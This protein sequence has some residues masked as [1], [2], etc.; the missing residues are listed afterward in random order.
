VQASGGLE[1]AVQGEPLSVSAARLRLSS[2]LR[3]GMGMDRADVRW[4]VHWNLPS[5]VE[6]LY[7]ARGW[8]AWGGG[9]GKRQAL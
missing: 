8:G 6:G 9:A 5:S 7:Q 1:V 4:V 3:S 2:L